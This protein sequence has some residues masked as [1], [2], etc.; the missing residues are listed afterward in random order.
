MRRIAQPN[1]LLLGY[2]AVIRLQI[3]LSVGLRF[4]LMLG[5][6]C[7]CRTDGTTP[8]KAPR[9][10]IQANDTSFTELEEE[11]HDASALSLSK[12]IDLECVTSPMQQPPPDQIENLSKIPPASNQSLNPCEPAAISLEFKSPLKEPSEETPKAIQ[13]QYNHNDAAQ[14]QGDHSASSVLT[15]EVSSADR[16]QV[17]SSPR[18]TIIGAGRGRR[19]PMTTTNEGLDFPATDYNSPLVCYT[20]NGKM[21]KVLGLIQVIGGLLVIM[22]QTGLRYVVA[23]S[24]KFFSGYWCGLIVSFC[25]YIPFICNGYEC[26]CILLV[27]CSCSLSKI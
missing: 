3:C 2:F 12:T 4:V 6:F 11:E 19:E 18:A 23:I 15:T 16:N 9:P 10:L 27:F 13:Q 14:S 24:S 7:C 26:D 22:C 1:H 25:F 8:I 21:S 17:T 5:I 20:F